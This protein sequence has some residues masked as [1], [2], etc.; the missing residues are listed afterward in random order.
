VKEKIK[1]KQN[2]Y[3]TLSNKT[4]EEEKEVREARYK[5]A[6]KLAKKAVVIAKNNAYERLYQKL[7][8]EEGEKDVFKL[9][10]AN[11]KKTRDLG[12]V[13]CIKG[14]DGKVLAGETKN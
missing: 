10:R 13:R 3:A 7:E 12:N 2:A 1:E 8:T 11:E 6:K 4:L 14:E 5:G 9:A